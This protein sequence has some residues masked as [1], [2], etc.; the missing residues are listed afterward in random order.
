MAFADGV[1]EEPEFSA[2]AEAVETDSA[3]ATRL[4]ALVEGSRLAREGFATLLEPAPPQL[5]ANVRSAIA[6]AAK[7]PAWRRI[8]DRL[9]LTLWGASAVGLAIALIALPVGYSLG[10]IG[11]GSSP[12][13]TLSGPPLGDALSSLRSGETVEIA[14]G[15]AVVPVATFTDATGHVCREYETSG[16]ASYIAIACR[17]GDAWETQFF[18]ATSAEEEAYRPASG[19]AAIDAYLQAIGASTALLD[20]QEAKVLQLTH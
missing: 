12:L 10:Q 5:Q 14:K 13:E 15:L 4:Q 8:W 1:L 2:V 6:K 16:A 18:I 3:I 20:D 19:L 11:R 9:D 17:L 7:V